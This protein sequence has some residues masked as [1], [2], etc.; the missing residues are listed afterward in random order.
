MV[1]I[2][3]GIVSFDVEIPLLFQNPCSALR[4][5]SGQAII[6]LQSLLHHLPIARLRLRQGPYPK[7]LV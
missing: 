4:R 5:S 3:Q 2:E 7:L 6:T 1:N